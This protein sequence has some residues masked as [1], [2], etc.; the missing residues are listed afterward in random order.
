MPSGRFSFNKTPGPI[1]Q[2]DPIIVPGI[3]TALAPIC[4]LAPIN[5]PSLI[6]PVSPMVLLSSRK[7]VTTAPPPRL[8]LFPKT[9]S[10]IWDR[11]DQQEFLR[12]C[13]LARQFLRSLEL[14]LST[15]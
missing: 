2:S 8:T 11:D 9:L 7:L 5:D 12:K 6:R 15:Q 4:V 1:I 13:K 14:R 10:A 3:I